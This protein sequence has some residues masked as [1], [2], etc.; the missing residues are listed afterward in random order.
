MSFDKAKNIPVKKPGR[1]VENVLYMVLLLMLGTFFMIQIREGI[2]V[3]EQLSA[4]KQKHEAYQIQLNDLKSENDRLKEKNSLLSIQK[5]QLSENVLN[6]QGYSELA[7]S[8]ADIREMAGLTVVEGSGVTITLSDSTITDPSD[9]NQSSLIHSQDVQYIV[10]LL[11]SAGAKAIAINGE[12]IVCTTSIIC[13]GPTIRVNN[14]RYPVPFVIMAVCDKNITYDI[15][16]NDPHILLRISE[17]V[18]IAFKK[19]DTLT[20]P[21]FSDS[22]VINSLSK[23]L[24][25]D[26]PS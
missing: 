9:S 12:R 10:D 5:D 11:K 24:G 26:K 7:A 16:Q 19:N 15:L 17:G 6:E 21:A 1:L 20:I 3:Q 8:L 13:T 22:A 18:E 4:S 25:G 2:S 23:E 14:S